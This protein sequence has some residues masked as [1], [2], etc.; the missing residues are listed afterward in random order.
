MVPDAGFRTL[1]LSLN[2]GISTFNQQ[3]EYLEIHKC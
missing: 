1:A 2:Q 3:Q